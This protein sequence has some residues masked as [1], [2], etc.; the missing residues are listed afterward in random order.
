MIS[1]DLLKGVDCEVS[2]DDAQR[3][4]GCNER[5]KDGCDFDRGELFD[6]GGADAG[7]TSGAQSLNHSH[8]DEAVVVGDVG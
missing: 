2:A 4:L 5:S 8:D 6:E 3:E 7:K 1:S